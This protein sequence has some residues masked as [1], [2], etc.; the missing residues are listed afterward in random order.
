MRSDLANTQTTGEPGRSDLAAPLGQP[1]GATGSDLEQIVGR[2]RA[3]IEGVSP[4]L[5]S[6]RFAIKRV[7]GETVTVQADVFGDGHDAVVAM[8][9][10]RP[11]G[12]PWRE[13][14][15]RSLGNDRWQA[16]F[17]VDRLGDWQYTILGWVDRF[18]TWHHDLQ[19]RVAANQVTAVDLA[20]GCDLVA[21]T[22]QRAGGEDRQRLEA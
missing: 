19:K 22:V 6:G 14:R 1:S 20:I 10:Y 18:L 15:M 13:V 16:G 4:E 3:V 17:R 12:E 11:A 7:I 2:S 9:L 8:L 5:D 21:A